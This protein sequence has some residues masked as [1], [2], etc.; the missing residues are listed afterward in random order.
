MENE[1]GTEEFRAKFG[2]LDRSQRDRLIAAEQ[3]LF[4][5]AGLRL[6]EKENRDGS[7]QSLPK[8]DR[9]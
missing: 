3:A 7:G 6:S 4:F 8:P 9:L 1:T 2:K 5:A